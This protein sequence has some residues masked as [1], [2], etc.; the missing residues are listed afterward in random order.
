MK[1]FWISTLVVW[2]V[3]GIYAFRGAFSAAV[4]A[5]HRRGDPMRLAVFLVAVIMAGGTLRWI[6]APDNETLWKAV[7]VVAVLT[8]IYIVR[9]MHA[10]GRGPD[11]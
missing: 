8:A 9:L 6:L 5:S 4:F 10:Y 11:V 1:P 7:Y 2:I 3:V